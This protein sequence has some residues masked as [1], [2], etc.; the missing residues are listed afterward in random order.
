MVLASL[1]AEERLEISLRQL[2]ITRHTCSTNTL[3]TS[4]AISPG[5]AILPS[6]YPSTSPFTDV[7]LVPVG[8]SLLL[9]LGQSV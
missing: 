5:A 1:Q 8:L 6:E 3:A 2:N 4:A 7:L 9:V